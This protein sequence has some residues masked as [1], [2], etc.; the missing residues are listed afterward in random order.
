MIRNLTSTR[1]TGLS[2][3]TGKEHLESTFVSFKSSQPTNFILLC[4]YVLKIVALQAKL[5][6]AWQCLESANDSL[7]GNPASKICFYLCKIRILAIFLRLFLI[8]SF[9]MC[10]IRENFIVNPVNMCSCPPF[11]FLC[12][13]FFRRYW[14]RTIL[15]YIASSAVI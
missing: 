3:I 13:F 10:Y 5:F 1:C 8:W 2:K 4:S 9:P 14:N 7:F 6:D 15:R 11:C 12:C